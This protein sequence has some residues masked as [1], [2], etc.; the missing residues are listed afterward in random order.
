LQSVPSVCFS[1]ARKYFAVELP[2]VSVT[3]GHI[4]ASAFRVYEKVKLTFVVFSE[5]CLGHNSNWYD[6]QE[7]CVPTHIGYET[8]RANFITKDQSPPNSPSPARYRRQ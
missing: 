4:T 2:S 3:S 7:D 6:F 5:A 1:L 8:H